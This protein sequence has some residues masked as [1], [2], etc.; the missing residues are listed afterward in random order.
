[1]AQDVQEQE[2]H[3][4]NHKENCPNKMYKK[5]PP[6]HP[7]FQWEPTQPMKPI[8][9]ERLAFIDSLVSNR[10]EKTKAACS[11]YK[12]NTPSSKTILFLA[13]QTNQNKH[14]GSAFHTVMY[15]LYTQAPSQPNRV[16]LTEEGNTQ[17]KPNRVKNSFHTSLV[18]SQ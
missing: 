14:R 2:T 15:F 3:P 17:H 1:M 10:R 4:L 7:F 8:N 9:V 5:K 18:F 11:L 13:F 12:D 16:S 6:P